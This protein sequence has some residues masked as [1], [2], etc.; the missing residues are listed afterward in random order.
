M[1]TNTSA[2]AP[3]PCSRGAWRASVLLAGALA[4]GC[5]NFGRSR[6]TDAPTACP[7]DAVRIDA[8]PARW[9][10]LDGRTVCITAPLAITGNHR[11]DEGEL[12]AAFGGRLSTP[13]E[14]AAPGADAARLAADNA[15]RLLRLTAVVPAGSAD[16]GG[17]WRA[18]GTLRGVAGTLAVD[19][20]GRATLR[21]LA[22]PRTTPAPR[23][24]APV[25]GGDVRLAALN[26]HN[27]FNGDGAG[28]GFPTARGAKTPAGLARQQARLVATLRAL[29]PDA[30]ALMELENDGDGPASAQA[31]L[32]AAL[33]AADGGDWRAVVPP[34]RNG[35]GTDAIRVG[36]A[37]RADRLAP[38][39]PAVALG[40]GPFDT[41]SRPPL[42][43]AFR[44]G[45][46]PVF[47]LVAV[48]LK[49]KGCGN[50]RAADRDQGDGQA[51]YNATRT[52]SARRLRDWLAT[53]PTG[54][55]SGLT[56]VLGDFNAYA[57]EDPIRLLAEAGWRDAFAGA[58]RETAYSFVYDGQAG[59][60]D[61]ALLSPA[62]ASRL[63]GAAKW[64]ANAD[65]AP[66]DDEAPAP[67][68]A[69]VPWGASDHDPL[70][71]GLR[72][73]ARGP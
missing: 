28:G 15:R 68:A 72:L 21:L 20:S 62:L 34:G 64:H 19:G 6:S 2:H 29:A 14:Q 38:V 70:L 1:P 17:R 52:D 48:H 66:V 26:L 49:S 12:L 8:P 43:Q 31:Q 47:T 57:R 18:G 32:L 10:D 3:W 23:P 27:L 35:P 36:I 41:L 58:P 24:A 4:A 13:T 71:L 53:D 30:V 40:G 46:G 25:V 37:W 42:A 65:E 11:L 16:A 55:G 44:A 56:A 9:T 67:A 7:A 5:A 22:P 59:R 45:N 60:L 54:S 63:A 69:P 61:H 39:G 50:A 51:C 33:R 73:R